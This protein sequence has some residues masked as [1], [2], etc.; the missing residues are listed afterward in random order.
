MILN[1]T[2]SRTIELAVPIARDR[3][4]GTNKEEFFSRFST[5]ETMLRNGKWSAAVVVYKNCFIIN[6]AREIK[7]KRCWAIIGKAEFYL[8]NYNRESSR[9]GIMNGV[10]RIQL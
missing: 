10:Q 3:S 6:Y 1:Y 9:C 5:R 7:G 8:I 2:S 4:R